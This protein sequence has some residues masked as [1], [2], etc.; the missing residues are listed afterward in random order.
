MSDDTDK[1]AND[2][3]DCMACGNGLFDIML[4]TTCM[5]LMIESDNNERIR[6]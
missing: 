6:K 5:R 4:I 3:S 2:E 1:M